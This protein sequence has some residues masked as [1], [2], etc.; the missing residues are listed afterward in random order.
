MLGLLASTDIFSESSKWFNAIKTVREDQNLIHRKTK[1]F[2]SIPNCL[3]KVFKADE[4]I[5]FYNTDA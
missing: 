5:F 4:T 2:Y 3:N 1:R